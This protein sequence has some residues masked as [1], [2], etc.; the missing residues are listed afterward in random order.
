MLAKEAP[1]SG[2]T[3]ET[4]I[5]VAPEPE[6]TGAETTAGEDL[7]KVRVSPVAGKMMQEEGLEIKDIIA[8][9]KRIG[10]KEVQ[11]AAGM[12][13]SG[14]PPI[15]SG[16]QEMSREEKREKM[17][18][19]RRKLSQRMVAVKNETAMLTTFNEVDMS[20]IMRLRKT[21]QPAFIEKHA[22]KLGF[23]S[24]FVKAST[25][26]LREFPKVNSRIE[27]QEIISPA[28]CDV[29]I[30][31]QTEKGLMV[32]VIRNAESMGLPEIERAVLELAGKA[33]AARIAR[34]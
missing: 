28:Y 30:A 33:R 34:M 8:G 13:G 32:P 21:Y 5:P 20:G 3:G 9:L 14:A 25:V 12:S 10:K 31:V 19:L 29:G 15:P 27:G 16:D 24:F 22:V 6:K 7:S 23:M 11:L 2:K 17:S 18:N 1:P 26:A 4:G